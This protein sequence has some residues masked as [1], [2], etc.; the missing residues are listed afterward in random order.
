MRYLIKIL[1]A[2]IVTSCV[3]TSTYTKIEIV[4]PPRIILDST[5]NTILLNS[6]VD[7]RNIDLTE[8]KSDDTT[9]N[10][11]PIIEFM[12]GFKNEIESNSNLNVKIQKSP[13]LP[14][15]SKDSINNMTPKRLKSH[16]NKYGS[17]LIVDIYD[18]RSKSKTKFYQDDLY[19]YGNTEVVFYYKAS[20]FF[21]SQRIYVNNLKDEPLYWE[22]YHRNLDSLTKRIPGEAE[23]L[24]IASEIE[25][26]KFAAFFM[27]TWSPAL[28][29]IIS[30]GN[31]NMRL[32]ALYAQKNQW[33]EAAK[34]WKHYIDIDNSSLSRRCRFNMAV[35]HEVNGE[36]KKAFEIV[37]KLYEEKRSSRTKKYLQVISLRMQNKRKINQSI[38]QSPSKVQ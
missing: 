25:G 6:T 10:F 30:Y 32:A 8:L 16:N 3:T 36:L 19:K 2:L 9:I 12:K 23:G 31:N 28:R 4:T 1:A 14:F 37:R 38:I 27:P 24:Y 15:I 18:K 20:A 11:Y 21:N 35:Y 7:K 13:E 29:K 26:R 5:V 22:A 33:E 34:I 17:Q